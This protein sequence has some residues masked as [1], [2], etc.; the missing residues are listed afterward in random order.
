MEVFAAD[1]RSDSSP[2]PDQFG[3]GLENISF[4]AFLCSADLDI[5]IINSAARNFLGLASVVGMDL[6]NL[7]QIE[8]ILGINLNPS[9]LSSIPDDQ[10]RIKFSNLQGELKYCTVSA[11]PLEHEKCKSYLYLLQDNTRQCNLEDRLFRK[12]AELSIFSQVASALGS[13]L[14]FDEILQIILIA[15][16]AREGL[17]F[18]RAFLFLYDENKNQLEGHLAIGPSSPEEAGRIWGSLPDEGHTLIEVLR[19]YTATLVNSNDSLNQKVRDLIIPLSER[20]HL[21][22]RVVQE[23]QGLLVKPGNCQCTEGCQVCSIMGA[24]QFAAVPMVVGKRVLGVITADNYITS[25]EITEN[26]LS[27]LEVFANQAAIAIERARLYKS[28][29]DYLRELEQ[30]NINLRNAQDEL[31]KIERLSLWSELTSDIAHEFRNPASIIGG[32]AALMQKSP[33]LPPNLKEQAH[34]IY[35][36]C[37]R[38]ESALGAVLDFSKSF[39]Q[40]KSVSNLYE[41][42][43]ETADLVQAKAVGSA[44]KIEAEEQSPAPQ[45]E[46]RIDQ[47]KFAYY[48]ILSMISEKTDYRCLINIGF[49]FA[50]KTVKTVFETQAPNGL[51]SDYLAEVANP[52]AGRVALKISMAVESIKYNG[53]VLGIETD[54]DGRSRLYVEWPLARS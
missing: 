36:E 35:S 20:S 52:K 10:K 32:F 19:N 41:I 54:A 6:N 14:N 26:F 12:N 13:L 53:G 44:M 38:L 3:L 50:D 8:S 27:Q 47:V 42:V 48:T 17:G 49:Y 45:I 24:S 22:E 18:N 23:R 25:R 34:I 29:S 31:L 4:P 15:V 33:N 51:A 21:L 46:A 39:A 28:L 9:T 37:S 11:I 2:E 5:S 30:A 43:H 16:T 7:H 1:T 40:E